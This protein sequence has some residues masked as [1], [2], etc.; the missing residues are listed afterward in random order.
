M[1]VCRPIAETADSVTLRRQDF[2]A[3]LT[4]LEKAQDIAALR[5]TEARIA[6]GEEERVPLAVIERLM[7]GEHPV[8]VW[9]EHRSMTGRALAEA[10]A[11]PASYLSAIEAGQK[12]GSFQAMA[13][14][15]AALRVDM[16]D[17]KPWPQ[18]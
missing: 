15:A 18:E 1:T 8:R 17:L 13:A 11:I 3:L 6:A 9:R 5:E 4:E 2:E 10:A 14:L 7:A 12:P 16:E